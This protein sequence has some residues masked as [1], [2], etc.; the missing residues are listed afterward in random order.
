MCGAQ[1]LGGMPTFLPPDAIA[2]GTSNYGSGDRM[3]RLGHKL[4]Q[5][6]PVTVAFLGGSITW[7]RVSACL[8][9]ICG[10]AAV[11]VHVAESKDACVV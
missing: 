8:L 6:Q 9:R 5:G 4:L 10:L 3:E 7:G 11:L 2:R 1:I